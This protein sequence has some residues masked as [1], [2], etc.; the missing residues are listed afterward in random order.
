MVTR[1]FHDGLTSA[2][3]LGI[4]LMFVLWASLLGAA[5]WV[6]VRSTRSRRAPARVVPSP[7]KSAYSR[8]G[9][10]RADRRMHD[11]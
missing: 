1:W 9:D 8:T 5:L 2:G 3:V 11:D 7:E 10:A 4:M 6:V